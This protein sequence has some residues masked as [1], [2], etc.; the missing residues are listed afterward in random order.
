[1]AGAPSTCDVPIVY[2]QPC[3]DTVA[4]LVP[5]LGKPK[6]YWDTCTGCVTVDPFD[7]LRSQVATQSLDALVSAQKAVPK[8]CRDTAANAGNAAGRRTG[9]NTCVTNSP[10]VVSNSTYGTASAAST[11]Y[12]FNSCRG[13]C[14]IGSTD[15]SGSG[16]GNGRPSSCTF[17]G[18]GGFRI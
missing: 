1:M 6:P 3:C 5:R 4:C 18:Q 16:I 15:S 14:A 10:G 2:P 8:T 13:G 11:I 12:R 17:I 7:T 9:C